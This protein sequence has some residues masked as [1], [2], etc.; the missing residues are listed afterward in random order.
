MK[1]ASISSNACVDAPSTR[2]SMRIQKISYMNDDSPVSAETA[3]SSRTAA[4]EPYSPGAACAAAGGPV[5]G[6]AR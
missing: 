3:R 4:G 2:L 5:G 1:L 6:R